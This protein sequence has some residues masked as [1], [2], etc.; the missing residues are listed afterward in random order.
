MELAD[1]SSRTSGL[2]DIF[3]SFN[4][5]IVVF[6]SALRLGQFTVQIF[7]LYS[8]FYLVTCFVVSTDVISIVKMGLCLCRL[9]CCIINFH[10]HAVS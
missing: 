4:S 5:S 3:Y 7:F 8:L 6:A 10:I 2:A 1:R 9:K